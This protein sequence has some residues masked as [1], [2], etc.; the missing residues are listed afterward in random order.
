[1]SRAEDRGGRAHIANEPCTGP[2]LALLGA[3]HT[4]ALANHVE[5]LLPVLRR[6]VKHGAAHRPR[7]PR[8]VGHVVKVQVVRQRRRYRVLPEHGHQRRLLVPDGVVHRR[9]LQVLPGGVA[10]ACSSAEAERAG[11][12]EELGPDGGR[13][14]EQGKRQGDVACYCEPGHRDVSCVSALH[15][16]R[17]AYRARMAMIWTV[18]I[19]RHS[20]ARPASVMGQEL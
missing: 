8:D 9:L 11:D 18:S 6:G 20:P 3:A 19:R 12:E 16:R 5:A 17:S 7:R 2:A 4:S 1:M 10:L 15:G 13:R 14:R